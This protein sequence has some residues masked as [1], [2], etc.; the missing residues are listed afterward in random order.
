MSSGFG[1]RGFD[2]HAG[3]TKS[4]WAVSSNVLYSI[5]SSYGITACVEEKN[6]NMNMNMNMNAAK[7]QTLGRS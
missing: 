2:L 4:Q 6:M 3:K 7:V 5:Y 1:L